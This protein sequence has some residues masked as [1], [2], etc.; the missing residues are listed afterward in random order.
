MFQ[1]SQVW[2]FDLKSLF[3]IFTRGFVLEMIHLS[4][5]AKSLREVLFIKCLNCRNS[6]RMSL[7]FNVISLI[8]IVQ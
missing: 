5:V 7:K 1:I 4:E 8:K 3:L 2:S 6:R